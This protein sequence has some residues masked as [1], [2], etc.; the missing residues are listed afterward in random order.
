[1]RDGPRL[2][3]AGA[4]C[5]C[6]SDILGLEVAGEVVACG[7]D[8]LSMEIGDRV[9][10]LLPGGG[11]AAYAVAAAPLCLAIPAGLS[12]VEAAALPETLPRSRLA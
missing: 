1:L 2:G 12:V 11:Y 7:N 5:L 6:A 8:V 9:T 3:L 4:R 10:A